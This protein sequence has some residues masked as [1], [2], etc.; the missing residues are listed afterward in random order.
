MV[1]AWGVLEDLCSSGLHVPPLGS[2]GSGSFGWG[3]TR[4]LSASPI[5]IS[6]YEQMEI[7]HFKVSS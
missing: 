5:S 6:K 4:D 7:H 1:A 3:L 2:I